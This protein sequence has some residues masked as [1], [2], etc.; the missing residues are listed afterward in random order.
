MRLNDTTKVA[1]VTFVYIAV[2][3]HQTGIYTLMAIAVST[4]F[5]NA[6]KVNKRNLLI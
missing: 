5:T 3:T 1:N 4:L 6:R 2:K